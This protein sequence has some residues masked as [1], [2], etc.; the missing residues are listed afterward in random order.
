MKETY[1]IEIHDVTTKS[2]TVHQTEA[3]SFYKAFLTAKAIQRTNTYQWNRKT[4]IMRIE[5]IPSETN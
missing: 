2:T 3:N 1:E 5:N 4:E